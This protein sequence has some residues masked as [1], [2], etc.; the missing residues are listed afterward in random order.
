MLRLVRRVPCVLARALC[1]WPLGCQSRSQALVRIEC[2]RA[3]WWEPAR[4][5]LNREAPPRGRTRAHPYPVNLALR[6]VIRWEAEPGPTRVP[7]VPSLLELGARLPLRL[8]KVSPLWFPNPLP[9]RQ[10]LVV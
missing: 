4:K 2:Q 3:P 1:L 7:R 10:G 8:L 9:M 5:E 6:L